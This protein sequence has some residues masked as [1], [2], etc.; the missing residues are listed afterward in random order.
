MD[1]IFE[2]V[3][4]KFKC[5]V[6]GK[7][8]YED[9]CWFIFSEED[10]TTD[11][12][13]SYWFRCVDLDCD[14]VIRPDEMI[15]FYEEQLHRMESLIHEPVQFEDIL[16]Q[17]TDMLHPQREGIF[18]MRDLRAERSL[19]GILFNCLFNINKFVAFETRD[20]FLARHSDPDGAQLTP[21]ERFAQT[22]YIRLALEEDEAGGA[23]DGVAENFDP[24]F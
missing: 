6:Q 4:R 11:V 9:F 19:A 24:S 3:P 16:C 17:L 18:T 1:R 15:F 14:G 2:Q 20:P 23:E 7:M 21:W 5:K 10:K 8:G 22:E 12:A 13:L